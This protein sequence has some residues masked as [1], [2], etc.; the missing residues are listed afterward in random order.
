M[1]EFTSQPCFSF[2]SSV[3]YVVSSPEDR[4]LT[5]TELLLRQRVPRQECVGLIADIRTVFESKKHKRIATDQ[6]I[7]K[8][9][10]LPESQWD[11]L[12]AVKLARMLRPFEIFP[13]QLWVGEANVRGYDY[14]DFKSVFDRYLPPATR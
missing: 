8:L 2:H 4:G 7:F 1:R 3:T 11:E 10:G 5:L 6:L 14:E 9:K 13:R 12:T